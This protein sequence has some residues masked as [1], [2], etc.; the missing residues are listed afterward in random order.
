M[1][2]PPEPRTN[3]WTSHFRRAL[4]VDGWL[5]AC[6]MVHILTKAGR[7]HA[8]FLM[9]LRF[10]VFINKRGPQVPC[11][12][13]TAVYV[14]SIIISNGWSNTGL[15][16][17][18]NAVISAAD[19]LLHGDT[20]LWCLWFAWRLFMSTFKHPCSS[21]WWPYFQKANHFLEDS[22]RCGNDS[23][24]KHNPPKKPEFHGYKGIVMHL[25]RPSWLQRHLPQ[26]STSEPSYSC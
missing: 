7:L 10:N 8:F 14:I 19:V 26:S 15:D 25:K 6:E 5:H 17:H 24:M 16:E 4:T 18:W 22:A 13:M 3:T 23:P 20:H 12:R 9:I 1:V 21:Q 11:P 2:K